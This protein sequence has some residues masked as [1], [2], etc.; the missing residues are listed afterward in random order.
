MPGFHSSRP[1][2]APDAK[3]SIGGIVHPDCQRARYCGGAIPL[4]Q[5]DH[6]RDRPTAR[7]DALDH[8]VDVQGGRAALRIGDG[9]RHRLDLG[10]RGRG[11]G[12]ACFDGGKR[13]GF[14]E[15]IEQIGRRAFGDHHHRTYERHDVSQLCGTDPTL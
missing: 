15:H 12:P 6:R 10:N 9:E 13:A 3:Q 11:I 8:C 5:R 7:F 2:C 1:R 4:D 14:A